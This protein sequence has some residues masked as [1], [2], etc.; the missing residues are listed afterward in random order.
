MWA[1]CPGCTVG[2]AHGLRAPGGAPWSR[3]GVGG[4]SE[5]GGHAGLAGSGDCSGNFLSVAAV[6][7]ASEEACLGKHGHFRVPECVAVTGV[8]T[9][10]PRLL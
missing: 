8:A 2:G 3:H 10:V 4:W 9:G 7:R 5:E 6:F 1:L